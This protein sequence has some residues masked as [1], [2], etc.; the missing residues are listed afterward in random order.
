MTWSDWLRRSAA[1]ATQPVLSPSSADWFRYSR[2][3]RR[4]VTAH[5]CRISS[6][7]F[8]AIRRIDH[9]SVAVRGCRTVEPA[10]AP[11]PRGG[12]NGRRSV[13][14]LLAVGV[15]SVAIPMTVRRS[16]HAER[17]DRTGGSSG[18]AR[19]RDG[20]GR[21]RRRRR[22]GCRTHRD[23]GRYRCL[24]R[25]AQTVVL[26]GD[27]RGNQQEDHHGEHCRHDMNGPPQQC[28]PPHRF[29]WDGAVAVG[30]SQSGVSCLGE[31]RIGR[32]SRRCQ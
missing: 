1:A 14:T 9:P 27:G 16:R 21:C 10:S 25:T 32:P 26:L 12:L 24:G 20:R 7:L 31:R 30:A 19:H 18:R 17:V 2:H 13:A 29:R 6:D 22:G 3:R 11:A 5:A 23:G 28:G 8:V 4:W 15:A